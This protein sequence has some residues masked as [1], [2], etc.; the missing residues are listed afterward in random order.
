MASDEILMDED[1]EETREWVEAIN[2]VLETEG[3]ER[4]QYLLQRL[5]SKVTETIAFI[6]PSLLIFLILTSV[7]LMLSPPS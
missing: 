2:S 5:S 6:L 4:A 7:T 3:V 1:P